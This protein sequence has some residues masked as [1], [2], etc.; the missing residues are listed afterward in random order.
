M[1]NTLLIFGLLLVLI[2]HAADVIAQEPLLKN[3]MESIIQRTENKNYDDFFDFLADVKKQSTDEALRSTIRKFRRKDILNAV[4]RINI[5]RL[6][7]IFSRIQYKDELLMLLQELVAIPTDSLPGVNQY[8][9][10]NII[11]F[12]QVIERVAGGFGLAFRNVDNRIFEVILEGSGHTDDSFGIYT[13]GDVVPSDKQKWILEDGTQLDP[14]RM[15]LIGD[16]IYGRGTEDDKGPIVAALFAMKS[17]KESGLELKRDIRLII[18]TTE[19]IGG[20]GIKYYKER[21][22]IPEYNVVLDNLY[23]V[24]TAEKGFVLILA[25]FDIRETGGKGIEVVNITGGTTITQIPASSTVTL[26][27]PEPSKVKAKLDT[28]ADQFIEKNGR[29]FRIES[30][31]KEDTLEFT[32]YG[33]S[34]HSSVPETGVNP[35]SRAFVFLHAAMQTIPFRKNHFTDAIQYV[36]DNYGLDFHGKKMGIDYS[37]EFMGPL[38]MTLTTVGLNEKRLQIGVSGRPPRGKAVQDLKKE[39]EEKLSAYKSKTSLAFGHSVRVWD[40]MYRNPKG[41]WINILL[42]VYSAATGQEAK[43]VS[44][45]G[46]TTAK[47]LP[48]GVSFG[49]SMPGEKYMGHTANEFRKLSH[50]LL[51]T[52]M[53]TEMIL[54]IGNLEKL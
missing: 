34:A 14:Y 30:A 48:N 17:I 27:T 11:K 20:S 25:D 39:I 45:N 42:D 5:Y 31:T 19:E 47:F 50:L 23:P 21:Y 38:T 12:G 49:P 18:E 13:H 53:L 9:N 37:D 28:L 15:Q 43:P 32:V 26:R 2:F 22:Q 51:D 3:D 7:G 16:K 52:Q 33:V 6:T 35:I 10:P 4:D 36:Y 41:A 24:V 46:G 54:R 29:N 8:E 40:Y 1:K 44:S